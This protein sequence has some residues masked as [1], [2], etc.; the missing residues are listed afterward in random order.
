MCIG[1]SDSRDDLGLLS[2]I[3]KDRY[4]FSLLIFEL[5]SENRV[6]GGNRNYF[7]VVARHNVVDSRSSHQHSRIRY[8]LI[9][10]S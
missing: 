7:R 9:A 3:I 6:S 8:L 10:L 5:F 4:L 1:L 2:L